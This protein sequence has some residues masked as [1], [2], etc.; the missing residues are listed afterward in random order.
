MTIGSATK[1][2]M[3][4][5]YLEQY[6]ANNVH[7]KSIILSVNYI[8][9]ATVKNQYLKNKLNL[10]IIVIGIIKANYLVAC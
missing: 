1:K 5:Q 10:I 9:T 6:N 3:V 2:F 7:K 8:I 4:L